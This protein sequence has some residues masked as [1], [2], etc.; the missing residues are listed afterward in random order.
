[1]TN[2]LKNL[3]NHQQTSLLYHEDNLKMKNQMAV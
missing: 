2:N 1:M 3:K